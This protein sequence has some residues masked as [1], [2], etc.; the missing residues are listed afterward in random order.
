MKKGIH[1]E[2]NEITV[3]DVAG[4]KIKMYSTVKK[5]LT[6]DTDPSNH[7]AW[8]GQRT[9]VERGQRATKFKAKFDGFKL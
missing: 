6:L 7:P 5:D 9:T 1:P 3:T 8:T 2:Y 4:N